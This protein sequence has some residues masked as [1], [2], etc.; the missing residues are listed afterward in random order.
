[1]ILRKLANTHG[2]VMNCVEKVLGPL[3]VVTV[4]QNKSLFTLF[5]LI[6]RSK[7][8][9][10]GTKLEKSPFRYIYDHI[11][12]LTRRMVMPFAFRD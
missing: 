9:K 6:N 11:N 10:M 4:E 3:E 1:M 8:L 7:T 12:L 5:L 2:V